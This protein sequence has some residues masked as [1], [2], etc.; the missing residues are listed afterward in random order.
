MAEILLIRF[1]TQ[2]NESVNQN[3]VH[4]AE[5]NLGNRKKDQNIFTHVLYFI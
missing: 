5:N 1:K 3:F 4:H 2:V